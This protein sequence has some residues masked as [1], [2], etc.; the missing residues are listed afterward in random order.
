MRESIPDSKRSSEKLQCYP[1]Y[2]LMLA[3]DQAENID[4]LSLDIEGAE[5]AVLKTIP[6]NKVDI[7]MVMIEV[8][9]SDKTA[10]AQVMDGAGY[11][12]YKILGNNQDII[13]VKA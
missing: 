13:Y 11:R 12:V 2:S 3:I 5:L 1:L 6:W 10:I 8:N 9:H 7:K 4:F